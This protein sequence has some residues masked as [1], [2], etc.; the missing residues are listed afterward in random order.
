[1]KK[2]IYSRN[3][4]VVGKLCLLMLALS[5]LCPTAPSYAALIESNGTGKYEITGNDTWGLM[6]P[7]TD[8]A[9][10]SLIIREDASL[11]L[12]WNDDYPSSPIRLGI[13]HGNGNMDI[14]GGGSIVG[15]FNMSQP[16]A[17]PNYMIFGLNSVSDINIDANGIFSFS[18]L[19]DSDDFYRSTQNVDIPGGSMV[20]SNVKFTPESD[21]MPSYQYSNGTGLNVDRTGK[22]ASINGDV[23]I[24]IDNSDV[25]SIGWG[26]VV[27]TKV[28]L[29]GDSTISI[30][31][32][33]IKSY[34]QTN[35]ARGVNLYA[36]GGWST[37]IHPTNTHKDN[38]VFIQNGQSN[39]ILKNVSLTSKQGGWISIFAGS[40]ATGTV[41]GYKA[42]AE[43]ASSYIEVNNITFNVSEKPIVHIVGGGQSTTYL[44][45]DGDGTMTQFNGS[46]ESHIKGLSEILLVDNGVFSGIANGGTVYCGGD[47]IGENA[48][49]TVGSAK[50]TLKDISSEAQSFSGIMSGQGAKYEYTDDKVG[51]QVLADYT[52]SVLGDSVLVLDNVKADM[53]SDTDKVTVKYFD[54]IQ[55]AN[56]TAAKL[57][58]LDADVKRLTVTG[59]WGAEVTA[60]EFKQPVQNFAS[61]AV[62]YS[63]A[64][65]VTDAYFTDDGMKFIVNGTGGGETPE[66]PTEPEQ[67]STDGGSGGGG[68]CN[69]GFGFGG[70]L[71]FAGLAVILRKSVK[72]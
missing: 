52:D 1:M 71:A 6:G 31:D 47:I 4:F 21:I 9:I 62:D 16:E 44:D 18:K 51:S 42:S 61:I 25:S 7:P 72:R 8:E 60:L 14:S 35:G 5:L 65:G 12:L 57:T 64:S 59:E 53:S 69:A 11:K 17:V 34:S 10:S 32:A 27:A 68:G 29:N 55:I 15:E 70:L 66:E 38:S 24:S 26:G 3:V 13:I 40:N 58:T 30:T 43:I 36:Q 23:N 33:D 28:L 67:P 50:L 49:S 37:S 45:N 20:I 54:E 63:E 48:S 41:D 56:N 39:I 22:V 19:S 2:L 46:A